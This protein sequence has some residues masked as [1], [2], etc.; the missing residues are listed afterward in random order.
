M[1]IEKIRQDFPVLSR[2]INGKPIIYFDNSCMTLRPRQVVDAMNEYYNNYPA[3]ALRSLHKLSKEATEKVS[4]SR[5]EVYKFINSKKVEEVIFT[6]NTTESINIVAN[7]LGLKKDDVVIT[8]DKEHNSNNIPWIKLSKEVG[9]KRKVVYSNS[10]NT[11]SIDNFE[12][13]MSETKKIKLVSMVHTSNMDG[14]TNPIKEIIK[15][16][17]DYDAKV[18]VD[19]AQSVPHKEIDVKKLDVDFLAFSSHKML[20][21]SGMGV[22]YGKKDLLEK[23]DQFVVGG[24]TVMNSTYDSY[25][26]EELPSKYEAGLQNYAGIIGTAEA[27]RYLKKISLDDI[28]KHEVKLNKHLTE[29]THEIND[30][31]IFGP[32]DAEK[33]GGIFS[34]NIGKKDPHEIAMMI[35]ALSNVMI[36]S[37]AHCVHSWFNAHNLK[38]SARA[39]FYLYNTIEEVDVFSKTLKD[40]ANVIK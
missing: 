38:G 33:R 2:K 39:S 28:S 37:G 31:K 24:E 1:N 25:I 20:G 19:A 7:T 6:K 23:M 29:S 12:K 32:T 15:I 22:L 21:P 14:V 13:M 11:F 3:C 34:F 27:C 30:L 10:D 9:V 16:A 40:V 8:T 18:L 26:V 35:D 4:D 36:R 5:K 17:H